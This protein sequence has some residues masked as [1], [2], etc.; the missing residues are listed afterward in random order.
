MRVACVL[1]SRRIASAKFDHH[2]AFKG[3]SISSSEHRTFR[4]A[5]IGIGIGAQEH[6]RAC[7]ALFLCCESGSGDDSGCSGVGGE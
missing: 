2:P 5:D 6:R 3:S 4:T 7:P 1:N